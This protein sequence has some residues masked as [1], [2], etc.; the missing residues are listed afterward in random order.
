WN[1]N[2]RSLGAH[3]FRDSPVYGSDGLSPTCFHQPGL[4]GALRHLRVVASY[5]PA[6]L[7][8][9]LASL[10]TSSWPPAWL[11]VWLGGVYVWALATLDEM[12]DRAVSALGALPKGRVAVFPT[13]AAEAVAWA[14]H[15][16]VL[17]GA[18]GTISRLEGF[19]PVA[20]TPI[21]TFLRE[22]EIGWVLSDDRYWP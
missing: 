15:H 1:R 9:P 22:Y 11:L 17:W 7:V 5:A 3:Q 12:F 2:W 19:F 14:T 6:N 13:Q 21:S 20:T 10:A 16:A 8:L 4:R 18:H